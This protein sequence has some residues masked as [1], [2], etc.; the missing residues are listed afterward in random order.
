MLF[1]YITSKNF[2]F[3]ILVE[4]CL[5]IWLILAIADQKFRPRLSAIVASYL[6]FICALTIADLFGENPFRSFWSN[7]SRMEGLITHLHLLAYFFVLISVMKT[8]RRWN[9]FFDLSLLVCLGVA[10]Y[11]ILQSFGYAR[12]VSILRV[13][14]TFGNPSYLAIYMALHFFLALYRVSQTSKANLQRIYG[15]VGVV[16]LVSLYLTQTRSAILGL[17]AGVTFI[18]LSLFFKTVSS[19]FRK[20]ML[21]YFVSVFILATLAISA[22]KY[23]E[24]LPQL[25]D[26]LTE[27]SGQS[28]QNRFYIWQV[29]VEAFLDHPWLGYGQENFMYTLK[30]Y[31]PGMWGEAWPDRAHNSILEWLISAGVVGCFSYLAVFGVVLYVLW[32]KR[33]SQTLPETRVLLT[34]FLVC[35]FLN[36]LFLFDN[37]ITYLIFFAVL[38]HLHFVTTASKSSDEASKNSALLALVASPFVVSLLVAT[39]YF[40]NYKNIEANFTLLQSSIPSRALIEN[41]TTE[42][43]FRI[44][45]I[46]DEQLLSRQEIREHWLATA[47]ALASQP[48]TEAFRLKVFTQAEQQYLWL[49]QKDPKNIYLKM[50][51]GEFYSNFGLYERA[52]THLREA[53]RISPRNQSVLVQLAKMYLK[54]SDFKAAAIIYFDIYAL[55]PSLSLAKMYRAAGFIYSD[56]VVEARKQLLLIQHEKN[57]EAFSAEILASFLNRNFLIDAAQFL[58]AKEKAGLSDPEDLVMLGNYFLLRKQGVL[59]LDSFE[60]AKRMGFRNTALLQA[61]VQRAQAL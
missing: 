48:I 26:R 54:K 27:G 13:D 43:D 19:D 25:A 9:F 53:M 56:Q 52:E 30:Y 22:A 16:S 8:P 14:G 61:L 11:S 29:S 45:Q 57:E 60:K 47:N 41:G 58:D 12:T 35:Y 55:E 24:W 39:I 42:P 51:G 10:V 28:V 3:R 1:P 4:V 20:T 37:V 59:A 38:A 40:L 7:Y 33:K 21:K 15:L 44:A 49:Q 36:N 5:S 23:F 2:V 6:V 34:A 17:A 18:C 46:L 50:L 31:D 32:F